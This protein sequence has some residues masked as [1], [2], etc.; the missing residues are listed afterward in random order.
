LFLLLPGCENQSVVSR[1]FADADGDGLR[2]LLLIRS[3]FRENRIPVSG[4]AWGDS[5]EIRLGN[6]KN[7]VFPMPSLKPLMVQTGDIDGD[8]REE[9]SLMV[10]KTAVFDPVTAKRP[11]FYRLEDEKL[12]PVWRGSRFSKPADDYRLFDFGGDGI[13]EL[14]SIERLENGGRVLSLYRWRGF[15][16]E[17][18]C[19]S[20]ELPSGIYFTGPGT[21]RPLVGGFAAWTFRKKLYYDEQNVRLFLR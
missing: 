8:G 2:D 19:Q 4:E 9:I 7:I 5:L 16:F 11:F 15:G 6:G 3:S 17:W 13:A 12:R 1:C 18:I 14:V 20:E 10:Y 21:D